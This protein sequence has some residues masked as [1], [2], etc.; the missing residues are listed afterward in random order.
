MSTPKKRIAKQRLDFSDLTETQKAY[1]AGFLDGDGSIL[2]QCLRKT[3]YKL[4]FQIRISVVFHQKTRRK[5]FLKDLSE[6]I[7]LG[8]LREKKNG[9]SEYNIVGAAATKPLLEAL[10][11][12]L[13]MKQRQAN[14]VLKILEQLPSTE[15]NEE[16]FLDV[17][18]LVDKVSKANDSKQKPPNAL[19]KAASHLNITLPIEEQYQG[20]LHYV[21]KPDLNL[22][23]EIKSEEFPVETSTSLFSPYES[24]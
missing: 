1:T 15:N 21:V 19:Q 11:P 6:E 20:S 16:R 12:Y 5:E 18:R 2:A 3:D 10:L 24:K 23:D 8:Q 14:L 17:C 22:E 13:R 9:M 4:G 7:G